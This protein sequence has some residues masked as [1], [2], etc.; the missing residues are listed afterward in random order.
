MPA[1]SATRYALFDQS[2]AVQWT[3]G[4]NFNGFLLVSV[5]LPSTGSY[6]SVFYS[7]SYPQVA[8]PDFLVCP[9][10]NGTFSANVG[11]LWNADI[12]PPNTKYISWYYDSTGRQVAGPSAVW[13]VTSSTASPP[14]ATLTAPTAGTTPFTPN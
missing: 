11:I 14:A 6:T 5:V 3:D 4:S 13:T 1:P 12:T 8:V 10:V 2:T 7:N 9:I